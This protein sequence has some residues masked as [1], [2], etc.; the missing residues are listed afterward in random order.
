VAA[1]P[2]P[3][4]VTYTTINMKG[5]STTPADTVEVVEWDATTALRDPN[6]T[7]PWVHWP[8]DFPPP[9]VDAIVEAV[10]EE[11]LPADPTPGSEIIVTGFVSLVSQ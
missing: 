4:A 9:G 5:T 7:M 8:F 11:P 1:A 3:R 2:L 10:V 6:G